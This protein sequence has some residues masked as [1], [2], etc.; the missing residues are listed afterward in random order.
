MMKRLTP[1]FA[2]LC[3]GLV[4]AWAAASWR[5]PTVSAYYAGNDDGNGDKGK[6]DDGYHHDKDN[7]DHDDG[8]RND[9][10]DRD[11]K[12][13]DH[14]DGDH[15]DDGGYGKKHDG[16]GGHEGDDDGHDRDG[17]GGRVGTFLLTITNYGTGGVHRALLT[18]HRDRTMS[19]VDSGQGN[20]FFSSQ[21]GAWKGKCDGTASGRTLEFS[22]GDGTI[23]RLDYSFDGD[24]PKD[25]VAGT[26]VLTSFNLNDDPLG[27][28]GT[29]IAHWE[30]TGTQVEVPGGDKDKD[31]DKDK[32][33]HKDKDK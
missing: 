4:A 11:H 28:G 9:D 1:F 13:G 33:H 23:T 2:I 14:K 12:D 16:D 10:G 29:V 30:F 26:I 27:D 25:T 31:K 5:P 21:L 32:D 6:G 8:C 15:K 19:S 17:R 18:L 7:K 20:G 24:Q 3:L 22:F